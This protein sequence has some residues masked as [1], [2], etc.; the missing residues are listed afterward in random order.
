MTLTAIELADLMRDLEYA[1]RINPRDPARQ[2]LHRWL[3]RPAV[4]D[5]FERLL[6]AHI[7]QS[8]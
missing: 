1:S 5:L 4:L 2:S 3:D 7:A 8:K 6:R